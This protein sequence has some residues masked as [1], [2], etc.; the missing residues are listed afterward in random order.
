MRFAI[1]FYQYDGPESQ[2][3]AE[4]HINIFWE[5]L[6]VGPLDFY[7]IHERLEDRVSFVDRLYRMHATMLVTTDSNPQKARILCGIINKFVVPGEWLLFKKETASWLTR[8]ESLARKMLRFVEFF[9]DGKAEHKRKNYIHLVC[10]EVDEKKLN[11]RELEEDVKSAG[12]ERMRLFWE[13]CE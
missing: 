1:A 7:S 4:R 2:T 8:G 11:P 6:G 12:E 5:E 10:G 3:E 13:L 9:M